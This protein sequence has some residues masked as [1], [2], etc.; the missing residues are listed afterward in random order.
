MP[1][2]HGMAAVGFPSCS[3]SSAPNTLLCHNSVVLMI[4][5]QVE[6]VVQAV[7]APSSPGV[8]PIGPRADVQDACDAQLQ[9]QL[10]RKCA[11]GL[12]GA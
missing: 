5:A 8:C 9:D 11:Y 10:R 7:G 12:R 3:S 1:A 2:L 6:H 4:E